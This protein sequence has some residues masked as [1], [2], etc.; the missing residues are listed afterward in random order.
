MVMMIYD[1]DDHLFERLSPRSKNLLSWRPTAWIDSHASSTSRSFSIIMR[2]MMV[3]IIIMTM[4]KNILV[5]C[6]L[7]LRSTHNSP[8]IRFVICWFSL[9]P[10]CSFLRQEGEIKYLHREICSG[11]KFRRKPELYL[12]FWGES[13][14]S[15]KSIQIKN[16]SGPWIPILSLEE[17]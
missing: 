16:C 11:R 3:M 17:C 8:Q 4:S 1:D 13:A 15:A 9:F 2:T 10:K 5:W 6:P 12:D 14:K 7:Q